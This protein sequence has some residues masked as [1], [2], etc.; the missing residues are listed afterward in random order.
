MYI[1]KRKT[2]K[3]KNKKNKYY[4]IFD[5]YSRNKTYLTKKEIIKLMKKEFKLSYSSNVVISL[6]N[7]WGKRVNQSKVIL[8][9]E[10]HKL[11]KKPDG[12]FRDI[13]I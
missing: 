13:L 3:M 9:E 2:I 5:K 11:F 1:M 10:F 4:R 12:F 7:I 8:K 6:M